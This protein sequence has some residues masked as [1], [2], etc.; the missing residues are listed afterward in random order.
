MQE[1]A[2]D[3]TF[4]VNYQ[5]LRGTKDFG[6]FNHRSQVTLN[7]RKRSDMPRHNI[8]SHLSNVNHWMLSHDNVWVTLDPQHPAVVQQRKTGCSG[9]ADCPESEEEPAPWRNSR[10]PQEHSTVSTVRTP[11]VPQRLGTP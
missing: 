7:P 5:W 3:I 10:R 1:P 4:T 11:F 2:S 8:I 6:F 9:A